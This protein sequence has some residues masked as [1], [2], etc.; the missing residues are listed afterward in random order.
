MAFEAEASLT[1][2][3]YKNFV[4]EHKILFND[5]DYKLRQNLK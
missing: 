5:N 3:V 4:F 1:P 2:P